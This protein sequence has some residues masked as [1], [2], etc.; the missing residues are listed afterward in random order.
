VVR[1]ALYRIV[2]LVFLLF[3]LSILSFLYMQLVPGDPVAGMLGPA[4]NPELIAQLRHQFGLD[5]P[6]L[7]QYWHWLSG[8]VHGDLGISFASR[9]PIGPILIH[10]IPATLQLTIASMIWVVL[11][12]WPSGFLAG[13]HKDTWVDRVFSVFALVGLSMPFFWI[14]T[15]LILVFSVKLHLLP[16]GGYVPLTEDPWASIKFTIMPSLALGLGL[17]P[18]LAR[19]TRAATVEVQQEQFVAH[20]HAKGLSR[21]RIG[22][23]Y[24]AR[25]AVLPIVVVLGLQIGLLLGGQVI[26]EELFNWPGVGR[27]LVGGVIQRDY[28][29]VQAVILVLAALYALLN[30]AAELVHAW[31]DPRIR[32]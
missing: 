18:Y 12:G 27:L 22:R 5:Q 21:R 11:I 19:M 28:F 10:R 9:Q 8:A 4:G 29:M 1:Y 25:N 20:A 6:L 7:T 2:V 32:L 16:S 15:V 23:R 30:L 3:G 24:T 17:A 26:I 14:G 13:L 31:L